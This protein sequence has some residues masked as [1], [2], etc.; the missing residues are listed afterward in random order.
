MPPNKKK[1]VTSGAGKDL[2]RNDKKVNNTREQRKQSRETGKIP[3]VARPEWKARAEKDLKFFLLTYMAAR[4]YMGFSDDHEEL[5]KDVQDIILSY[6]QRTIAMPRGSGKTSILEGAATWAILFG[7]RKYL[8]VI[9]ATSPGAKSIMESI[10]GEI[11]FNDEIHMDFPEATTAVRAL[12]GISRRT[13]GQTTEGVPTMLEWN[14]D[15]VRLSRTA[16][17]G[18]AIMSVAGILGAIR[19]AK[20]PLADGS[21]V[22][23][24]MVLV[25]DFQTTESAKS[26]QQVEKRLSVINSDILGLCGPGKPIAAFVTCTV[27]QNG[28]GAQRLLDRKLNPSWQGRTVRM[29]ITM[30][31]EKAEEHWSIY[32]EIFEADKV[33]DSIPQA[34]KLNRSNAYYIKNR[35]AMDDGAKAGWIERKNPNEI[36]AIQHAINIR[37][38]RG[39]DAFMSEYQNT[40]RDPYALNGNQQVDAIRVAAR[41]NGIAPGVVPTGTVEL[42]AA[43]D[44][45]EHVLWWGVTAFGRGFR[46]DVVA[47][48]AWPQQSKAYFRAAECEGSLRKE[49]PATSIEESWHLAITDLAGSLLDSTDW[50]DENG[51]GH[52][53][54]ICLIDAGYGTS[55][56]TIFNLSR[57]HKWRDRLVPTFGRGIGAKK[58]PMAEWKREDGERRGSGWIQRPNRLRKLRNVMFDANM[59]KSFVADRLLTNP[60]PTGALMLP[61]TD[62]RAHLMLADHLTAEKRMQVAVIGRKVDEWVATPGQDNHLLDVISMCHVAASIKGMELIHAEKKK[63]GR[64]AVN[65]SNEP[66]AGRRFVYR[67]DSKGYPVRHYI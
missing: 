3:P 20:A 32:K 4:F 9:A 7:H 37:I 53:I 41:V 40:P 54:S 42:T 60:S 49:Y 5:I 43:I 50:K 25:D 16:I 8:F 2:T 55:T 62:P 31:S 46:G 24:D 66:N 26:P 11:A 45:G 14:K 59:W 38:E 67:P 18:G 44:V 52:R 47:Y 30:P 35:V 39:I 19:G 64:P 13:E 58:A 61:G 36:S 34:D 6:G 22:R 23:P 29:M 63:T 57:D 21:Q 65:T 17:G 48:G 27:I 12:E 33:D 51:Q 15:R 10:K 56:D 28:D 1:E